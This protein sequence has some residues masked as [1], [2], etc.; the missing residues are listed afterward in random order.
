ML[1]FCS[2][3]FAPGN[4]QP[5]R[6]EESAHIVSD[7]HCCQN[8]YAGCIACT[9]CCAYCCAPRSTNDV[10]LPNR[11]VAQSNNIDQSIESKK[12]N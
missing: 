7:P 9:L 8:T 10:T 6:A 12:M 3:V 2:T 11:N 1:L 5:N 4:S